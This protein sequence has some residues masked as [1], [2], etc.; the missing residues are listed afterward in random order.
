MA[1]KAA[2]AEARGQEGPRV[3]PGEGRRLHFDNPDPAG[4][5][6]RRAGG[7]GENAEP[8]DARNVRPSLADEF[9][10]LRPRGVEAMPA[11]EVARALEAELG[12]GGR[13]TAAL[14]EAAGR[15]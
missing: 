3:R 12:G 15:S 14:A 6:A 2:K 8:P 11:A 10:E 9:G 13:V 1:E 5:H 7:A 4:G